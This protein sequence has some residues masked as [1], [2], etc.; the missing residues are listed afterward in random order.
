[1]ASSGNVYN[2]IEPT[3]V[4]TTDANQIQSDVQN[5][6]LNTFGSDLNIDPSTPQ[7]MLITIEALSRIA[8]A[9]NNVAL[10]NQINPNIAGG[11]F[12]DALMQLLGLQRMPATNSTVSCTI[13][14]VVGTSIPAGAQISNSD[15]SVVFEIISLT[16]IPTG[17][18]ISNV[19]FQSVLTGAIAAPANTLTTIV[20]NI[21]GWETVTNPL[22]ATQGIAT[23]SDNQARLYRQNALGAQGNSIAANVIAALYEIPGVAQAG[24]TFQE[25]VS[26]IP[27]TINDILMVPH[28]IYTVVGGTSNLSAIASALTYG[29]AAGAAYN[30]GLGIP[31]SYPFLNQYS[32]QVIN[33]LFDLPSLVNISIQVTVHAFTTVQ[34]VTTSVQNAIIQ[35]ATGNLPGQSG[36]VVGAAVSPFQLAAA[37]NILVPGL[38]VQ[39]IQVGIESFT[40]Q[41]IITN[42]ANTVTGLTYNAPISP[43]IGIQTG[44]TITDAGSN[45]LPGTTVASIVGGHAITMSANANFASFSLQGTISSGMNTVTGMTSNAGIVVGM[46]IT[47][48]GIPGATT[49]A[50]L[51]GSTGITMSANATISSTETLTFTPASGATLTDIL[52]FTTT[53]SYQTTEIPIGVWQQA[54]TSA[55]Y[56]TVTSV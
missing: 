48:A 31:I 1:V 17:G 14:G 18:S 9:D 54:I 12:L 15:G 10:A 52:T 16:V 42:G 11:V 41:G 34:N 37:I 25:N 32:N 47:G 3:G 43:Y 26:S 45:I 56:I 38:F 19:P 22:A 46:G 29:K 2:Y 55:P 6:Y 44:M 7:G 35:Y 30:N 49:V 39:E 33:V 50:S 51:V 36:F 28:S 40:Q 5:E 8:V 21:L 53:P 4:I 20:S 23:Q 27:Q 13:T 24:V